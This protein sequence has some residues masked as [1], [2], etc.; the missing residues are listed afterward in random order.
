M[1]H[2]CL[3]FHFLLSVIRI[4]CVLAGHIDVYLHRLLSKS[5]LHPGIDGDYILAHA[6]LVPILQKKLRLR[7]KT[8]HLKIH[9]QFGGTVQ[10]LSTQAVDVSLQSPPSH[11][12]YCILCRKM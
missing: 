5:S 6:F 4:L 7:N 9:W 12:L 1:Q 10:I 11:S 2:N 3:T 8:I